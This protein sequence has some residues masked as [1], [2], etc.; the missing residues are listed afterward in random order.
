MVDIRFSSLDHAIFPIETCLCYFPNLGKRL[1]ENVCEVEVIYIFVDK[2]ERIKLDLGVLSGG[3]T[4]LLDI[5]TTW[6]II[7]I[8]KIIMA[9]PMAYGS[10]WARD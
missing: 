7:L 3:S 8:K 9:T 10:Y 6:E 1:W 5:Q 2:Q 4:H